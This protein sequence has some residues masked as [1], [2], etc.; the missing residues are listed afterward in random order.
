MLFRG[1]SLKGIFQGR[2]QKGDD[3][4][5]GIKAFLKDESIHKGI[6]SGIGAASRVSIG[7]YDQTEKRYK[8]DTFEEP[9]EILSIKGNISIKDGE[10]FPHLHGVF[11]KKD[12]TCLGGHIFEGTEVFAFEFEVL[13]FS[14]D[15][16]IRGYDE[17]TGL[18]LWMA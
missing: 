15:T 13:E 7:Y 3:L 18:Y 6:I 16:F 14:G 9:M 12:H 10:P 4:I 1:F 17:E 2:L 8:M 11:S 5:E